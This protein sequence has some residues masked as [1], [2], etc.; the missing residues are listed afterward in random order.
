MSVSLAFAQ[1]L[2]WNSDM[3]TQIGMIVTSCCSSSDLMKE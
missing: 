3:Y 2:V 1:V